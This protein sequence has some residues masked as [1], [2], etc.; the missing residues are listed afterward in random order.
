MEAHDGGEGGIHDDLS[1]AVIQSDLIHLVLT[2][3]SPVC[4]Y[5]SLHIVI[6]NCGEHI[7]IAKALGDP[8]DLRH[9]FSKLLQHALLGQSERCIV[10]EDLLLEPVQEREVELLD[11]VLLDEK[12]ALEVGMHLLHLAVR[13][14]CDLAVLPA[15]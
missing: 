15:I 10:S 14:D 6:V 11:P 9:P 2:H 3:V 8:A 12:R 13:T 7:F 5:E 4:Q 1:L